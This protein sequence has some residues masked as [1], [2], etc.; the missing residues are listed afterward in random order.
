MR[1]GKKVRNNKSKIQHVTKEYNT[2]QEKGEKGELADYLQY[3]QLDKRKKKDKYI[4]RYH[5]TL[6]SSIQAPKVNI[7]V[8]EYSVT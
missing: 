4:R 3:I 5:N 1:E 8:Y 2:R 6:Q 7:K